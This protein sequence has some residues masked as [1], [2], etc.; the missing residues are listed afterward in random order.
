MRRALLL[1]ASH[2]RAEI[3]EKGT[4][5]GTQLKSGKLTRT[6]TGTSLESI[7]GSLSG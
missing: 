4:G 5:R 7:S 3:G 6:S 2:G 1:S